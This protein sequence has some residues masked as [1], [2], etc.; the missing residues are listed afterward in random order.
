MIYILLLIAGLELGNMLLL[1]TVTEQLLKIIEIL[2]D[3]ED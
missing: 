1:N 2:I 3:K